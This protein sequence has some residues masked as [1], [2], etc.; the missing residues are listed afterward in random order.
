[1]IIYP[2]LKLPNNV[3]ESFSRRDVVVTDDG[4]AGVFFAGFLHYVSSDGTLCLTD[5]PPSPTKVTKYT[6][7]NGDVRFYQPQFLLSIEEI[8]IPE[9]EDLYQL[10]SMGVDAAVVSLRV[11]SRS[12]Q[13]AED[14]Y[15]RSLKLRSRY[16]KIHELTY[17]EASEYYKRLKILDP[18]IAQLNTSYFTKPFG[19]G[20]FHSSIANCRAF[21]VSDYLRSDFET[22]AIPAT[23]SRKTAHKYIIMNI[24]F[25]NSIKQEHAGL[26]LE[27]DR[28]N[29]DHLNSQSSPFSTHS[30]ELLSLCK[31]MTAD[32]KLR[33]K[34]M[35]DEAIYRLASNKALTVNFTASKLHENSK[36]LSIFCASQFCR[37]A[38]DKRR[39]KS[40]HDAGARKLAHLLNIP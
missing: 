38:N 14:L 33:F 25:Q 4:Y 17:S 26:F 18:I 32:T 22:F 36:N 29:Y 39:I 35:A 12:D 5:F 21:S 7:F 11:R 40:F 3:S 10:A 27:Q 23:L 37:D 24:F 30:N 8:L 6:E 19:S 16:E 1:M 28:L 20:T 2:K 34:K 15:A 9:N 13:S 31:K